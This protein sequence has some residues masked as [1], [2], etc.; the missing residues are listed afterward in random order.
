LLQVACFVTYRWFCH[1]G[2]RVLES[3]NSRSRP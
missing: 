1:A 2:Y 3:S